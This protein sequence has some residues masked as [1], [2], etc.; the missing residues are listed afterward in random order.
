METQRP[1]GQPA[2]AKGRILCVTSN[3]P[4]WTGDSTTPF[5]LHLAQDLQRLGW[6][7]H[8]LAP[9]A[10][11][12][13]A[14][15]EVI[16]GVRVERFSY[17]WPK[18]AQTVCYHGGALVNLRENP[19][20]FLKLPA[21]VVFQL[22]AIFRRLLTNRYDAIHSHWVLPQGF[23]GAIASML[24]NAPQ[25]ITVHGG[26]V[27]ALQGTLLKIF[28]RFSLRRAVT[29]TTNSSVTRQAVETIEP[30]LSDLKVVPMGV[31][32]DSFSRDDEQVISIRCQHLQGADS[33]MVFAGRVV[34]EKGVEDFIRAFQILRERDVSVSAVIVGEGQHREIF[35]EM[36]HSLGLDEKVTFTGWVAPDQVGAYLAAADV[37]VGP[38]RTGPDGWVEAQGLTF[39]EAMI[40]RTPVIATR[41]GGIVDSVE[42]EVT[43]L[44]VDENS[45]A[46]IADAVVRLL[47][48]RGL[49]SDLSR[50]ANERAIS[51]FS[52]LASATAFSKVFESATSRAAS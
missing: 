4:R 47:E 17:L 40:A 44:L 16:G 39:I 50:A 11:R 33:L 24:F 49:A 34:E 20:N 14:S 12:G 41:C 35:Q 22:L 48:D 37:F 29:V 28:K 19:L 13:T 46:Q 26:D 52:R 27:F 38:S 43:G 6:E 7:V 45:P 15:E 1:T 18:R 5:V 10:E 30:A 31:S 8:I 42:H 23:T 25:V 2:I 21:L 36:V 3:F 32:T 51:N 9:H